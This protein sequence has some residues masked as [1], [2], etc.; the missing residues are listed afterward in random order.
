MKEKDADTIDIRPASGLT[1]EHV[2]RVYGSGAEHYD[3]IMSTVYANLI[4]RAR[5]MEALAPEQGETLLEVGIG[6]GLNLPYYGLNVSL[7]GTDFTAEMLAEAQL[8]R[9]HFRGRKLELLLEDTACLPF[10]DQSFDAILATLTLCAMPD[11][12]GGLREMR[13]V[14]RSGGRIVIFEMARSPHPIIA[15]MQEVLIRPR[16]TTVGF[17]APEPEFPEGVIVWDPARDYLQIGKALELRE[18]V[19]EW[20]D[21]DHPVMAR[22]L[23]AWTW[24]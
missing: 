18:Q 19:V 20:I 22:C 7:T 3:R 11:P 5:V 10:A 14:C 24:A 16:T 13:R 17:P 4:D 23:I 21:A 12:E 15:E 6:T 2:R 8:K 9:P 1:A